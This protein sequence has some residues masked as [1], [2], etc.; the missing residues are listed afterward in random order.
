MFVATNIVKSSDKE[1]W[2]YSDYGIAFDGERLW[3]F[4]KDLARN[5][6]VFG[7]DNI[8]SSHTDNGKNKF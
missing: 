3:N 4:G 7:L 2:L 1:K 8:L 6:V 5:V